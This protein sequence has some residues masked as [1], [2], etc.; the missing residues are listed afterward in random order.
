MRTIEVARNVLKVGAGSEDKIR[1]AHRGSRTEDKIRRAYRGQDPPCRMEALRWHPDKNPGDTEAA[2]V[3]FQHVQAAFL[4][5]RE[6]D[7]ES[8]NEN[9]F[10]WEGR[11]RLR[12]ALQKVDWAQLARDIKA[13]DARAREDI[14]ATIATLPLRPTWQRVPSV[15]RPGKISYQHLRTGVKQSAFPTQEP[16]AKKIAEHARAA[17]TTARAA[18]ARAAATAAAA[19]A[20]AAAALARAGAAAVARTAETAAETATA[21]RAASTASWLKWRWL[22]LGRRFERTTSSTRQGIGE[23]HVAA[24]SAGRLCWLWRGRGRAVTV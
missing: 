22:A 10:D 24:N 2:T 7:A 3:S 16:T 19:R 23:G 4:A 1:R 11:E 15:S 18:A 14:E 21:A 9:V 5:L 12:R 17:A 6:N 8:C 20:T 13:I